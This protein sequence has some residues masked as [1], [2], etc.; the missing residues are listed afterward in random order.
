MNTYP[1][2][3][4]N[5]RILYLE[6]LRGLSMII[7][8]LNHF[9]AA[10]YPAFIFGEKAH[11]HNSF[12]LIIYRTP[13]NIFFSGIFALITFY[14]LSGYF[15][16]YKYF[17][18][19]KVE[20]LIPTMIRRYFILAIPSLISILIAFFFLK[21]HLF[22]NI[23]VSSLTGSSMWFANFWNFNTDIYKAIAE[24]VFITSIF[25]GNLTYNPVLWMMAYELAGS[26]LVYISLEI[27]KHV[28]RRILVYLLLF[29]ITFIW[30]GY[31]MSFILGML[32][33]DM[34]F[35]SKM[36]ILT[37][38]NYQLGIIFLVLA[39]FLG[40][41]PIAST[42]GTVHDFIKIPFLEESKNVIFFQTI[43]AVC[44]F[45]AIK[46]L[47]LFKKILEFSPLRFLGGISFA[48]FFLHLIIIG[49]FSSYLFKIISNYLDYNLSFLIIF[50]ISIPIIF[51]AG[52]YFNKLVVLNSLK[53]ANFVKRFLN[54][55]LEI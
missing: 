21:Y 52:F 49:S 26:F 23:P 35:K 13:L 7:V 9:A 33:C 40:S 46:N 27:F 8:V 41:F 4:I 32:I 31:L 30:K 2:K 37:K 17:R 14:L 55:Y 18:F 54:T 48:V 20:S 38:D 19:D 1:S 53:I 28:R 51:I 29:L 15:L 5:E 25:I 6:G 36:K 39:I 43:A 44:S 34:E 47:R 3:R 12:D 42:K 45:L 50:L 24:G 16:S 22:Y 10:F 11:Q